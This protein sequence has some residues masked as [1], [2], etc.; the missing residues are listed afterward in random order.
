MGQ[1]V[2]PSQVGALESHS[3]SLA[4]VWRMGVQSLPLSSL[5][6]PP[7]APGLSVHFQGTKPLHSARRLQGEKFGIPR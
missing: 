5:A 4:A 1:V 3:G 2:Q 7:R 6:A